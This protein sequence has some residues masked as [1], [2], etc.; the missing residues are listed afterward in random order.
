MVC[1]VFVFFVLFSLC[2]F[3]IDLKGLVHSRQL[4]YHEAMTLILAYLLRAVPT[5]Q[6]KRQLYRQLQMT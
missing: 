3:G 4:S 1:L 6:I 2:S 5:F